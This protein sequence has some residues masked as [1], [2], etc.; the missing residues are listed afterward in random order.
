MELGGNVATVEGIKIGNGPDA[1][2]I[3]THLAPSVKM[4]KTCLTRKYAFNRQIH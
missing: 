4:H 2:Q 1:A 3:V